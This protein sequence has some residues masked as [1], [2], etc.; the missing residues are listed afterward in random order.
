MHGAL[1]KVPLAWFLSLVTAIVLLI[2]LGI[3]GWLSIFVILIA[4]PAA[5]VLIQMLA[6][7]TV[8]PGLDR[9]P[10]NNKGD[11]E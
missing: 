8:A 9:F 7:F 5:F 10:G 4:T 11:N 1:W 6:V 2:T 3:Y